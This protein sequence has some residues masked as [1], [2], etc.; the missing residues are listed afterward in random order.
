V[1][2]VPH[3]LY[4]GLPEKIDV[5]LEG[6]QEL[7]AGGGVGRLLLDSMVTGIVRNIWK[8]DTPADSL[9]RVVMMAMRFV[10]VEVD[11]DRT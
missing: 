8:T 11:V 9:A 4:R 6:W 1:V 7:C 3:Y 2:V 5:D 10:E